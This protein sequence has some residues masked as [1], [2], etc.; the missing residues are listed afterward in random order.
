MKIESLGWKA[1][2]DKDFEEFRKQGFIPARIIRETRHIY[3]ADAGSG[4]VQAQVS[5][6][7]IFESETRADYPTIGDW[8]ACRDGGGILIIEELL[9][10]KSRFSR[11]EAGVLTEEQIIA[12]NID[13]LCIVCGLDG[14]RNFSLRGIERYLSMAREVGASPVIVLNKCDIAEDRAKA[15]SEARNIAGDAQVF[16]V[17]ALTGEGVDELLNKFDPFST[18]AFSGPSGVGKSALVNSLLG[19]GHMRT[20]IQ[21]EDDLRGRHTTTHKELVVL[22][23]G[24]MLIDTPGLRE[25]QLWGGQESL[26]S[27]FSE[28]AQ[29]ALNCRF[30]DCSHNGEPGCAVI[31]LVESGTIPEARYMNYRDMKAELA[32]LESRLS[33]KGQLDRKKKEKDL[34][35]MQKLYLRDHRK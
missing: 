17:S 34:S 16:A 24:V 31:E 11:K 30:S 32:Y 22:R 19:S 21:R 8:V 3:E 2:N 20:G 26:D 18:I 5:G 14:G 23:N 4:A 33:E 1:A 27:S 10:R 25:L 6:R 13:F 9:P 12:A 7:F 29:A 28:I 35:R 15:V